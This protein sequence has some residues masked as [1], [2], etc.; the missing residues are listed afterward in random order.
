MFPKLFEDIDIV[1]GNDYERSEAIVISTSKEEG[2]FY[3][4]PRKIEES[5]I[6]FSDIPVLADF[7]PLASMKHVEASNMSILT[8]LPESYY[9]NHTIKMSLLLSGKVVSGFQR[10]SKDLGVPTANIEMTDENV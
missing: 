9:W 4:V 10:G 6:C 8:N 7:K 2:S 1:V 3:I 5:G